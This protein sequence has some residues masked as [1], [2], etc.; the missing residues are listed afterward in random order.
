M[1]KLFNTLMI[2]TILALTLTFVQSAHADDPHEVY[3]Q[4]YCNSNTAN[5]PPWDL[6]NDDNPARSYQW[7]IVPL[8]AG[9]ASEAQSGA[10]TGSII[11]QGLETHSDTDCG[12]EC[13]YEIW[14]TNSGYNCTDISTRKLGWG[15]WRDAA[16]GWCKTSF[17][18][19]YNSLSNSWGFDE[20]RFEHVNPCGASATPTPTNTPVPPTPTPTPT[21]TATPQPTATPTPSVSSLGNWVWEDTNHN[22]IQDDG[23]TGVSGVTVELFY[24]TDCSGSAARTLQTSSSGY[25]QFTNLGAGTYSIK[26]TLPNGYVWSPK[27]A[28]G[29][30]ASNDS[31]AECT[32]AINLPAGVDDKSWDA[33]IYQQVSDKVAIGNLVWNDANGNGQ[34]DSGEDGIDGATVRL[35]RDANGN[36]VCE[37][38]SDTEVDSAT[39]SG[40]GFYQ[41]LGVTPSTS[42]A[43]TNYCVAVD[44]SSVSYSHSSAGGNHQPDATGDQDQASGD[45]GVPVGSSVVSQVFPATLHGSVANDSGDPADYPD[46]SSYMSIDF[47]FNNGPASVKLEG[48]QAQQ[49]HLWLNLSALLIVL[50][51]GAYL[52]YRRKKAG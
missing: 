41:F 52:F 51:I 18:G 48:M 20:A 37:P 34:Q 14:I 23:N 44:K 46:D 22:G 30:T 15:R 42:D 16:S 29:S 12:G 33:G 49:N 13:S 39:T 25:Y 43:T 6:D 40:G 21:P 11:I 24:T 47:G 50:I 8:D 32:G 31:D 7:R 5:E 27:N 17:K 1:K 9:N 2:I 4:S 45:D 35:Y 28:A 10:G 26:F 3:L 19:E 38:G 36:G